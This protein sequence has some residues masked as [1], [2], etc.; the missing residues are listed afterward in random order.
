[1]SFESKDTGERLSFA[2]MAEPTTELRVLVV[3][4][5]AQIGIPGRWRVA[6]SVVI[7]GEIAIVVE[8][9]VG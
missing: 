6:G 4:P 5:P 2:M 7:A 8:R 1:M 9:V 3:K